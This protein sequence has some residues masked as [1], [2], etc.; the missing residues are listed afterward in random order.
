[1]LQALIAYTDLHGAHFQVSIHRDPRA[2]EERPYHVMLFSRDSE[3]LGPGRD[4]GFFRTLA[5]AKRSCYR[6]FGIS[7]RAWKDAYEFS[8]AR[9][10][11]EAFAREREMQVMRPEAWP[12]TM[13]QTREF[14][15]AAVQ[16][17][18][19]QRQFLIEAAD[20]V[21]C[22]TTRVEAG[23]IFEALHRNRISRYS[24]EFPVRWE[25]FNLLEVERYRPDGISNYCV[26]VEEAFEDEFYAWFPSS[27]CPSILEGAALS[28]C[29]DLLVRF[30]DV[31][32]VF[33]ATRPIG[34][35]LDLMAG[36]ADRLPGLQLPPGAF[37]VDGLLMDPER[38][39]DVLRPLVPLTKRWAIGD[40]TKRAQ[41]LAKA[42]RRTKQHLRESVEPLL[43]E[44]NRYLE[45]FGES[46]LT[47]EA[48]LVMHLASSVAMLRRRRRSTEPI[49]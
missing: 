39:P 5:D 35:A 15:V 42:A 21:F 7:R 30:G 17:E 47:D 44:V 3:Y 13:T 45:S 32:F 40:E 28:M 1:M 31:A 22:A 8:R 19:A 26:W 34:D 4:E 25:G 27:D 10:V 11:L 18:H 6:R 48:I 43:P 37:R 14:V 24:S 41:K 16:V 23:V 20:T 36:V 38:V 33:D 12:L 9:P 29:E 46:P 49:V 2:R